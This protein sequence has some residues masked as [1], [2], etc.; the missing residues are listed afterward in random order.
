MFIMLGAR[1]STDLRRRGDKKVIQVE[2]VPKHMAKH[3]PFRIKC[4][5][6]VGFLVRA[7]SPPAPNWSALAPMATSGA[8]RTHNDYQKLEKLG[9][10]TFGVVH[11]A[12]HIETG[13]VVA[14]KKMRL[15]E[16]EDGVPA[17]ALRE[18]AILRELKHPNIIE[19]A[20]RPTI[21]RVPNCLQF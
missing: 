13:D 11:K 21:A 12:R 1:L 14:L 15:E 3:M 4:G 16:E 17:T 10:G 5:N 2:D 8:K 9:E 20:A 6:V 7:P 19:Y 18:I